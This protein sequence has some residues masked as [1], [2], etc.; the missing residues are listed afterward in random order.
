MRHSLSES[1]KK[2]YKIIAVD[3]E[4]GVLDSL[5]VFECSEIAFAHAKSLSSAD[6]VIYNISLGR[7]VKREQ[8]MEDDLLKAIKE[9]ASNCRFNNRT[10]IRKKG[11]IAN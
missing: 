7:L 1:N 4:S 9:L 3:D 2:P 10:S 8:L 6:Y 11:T 5:K